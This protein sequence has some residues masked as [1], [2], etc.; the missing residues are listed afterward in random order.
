ME[1][2][3]RK[4]IADMLGVEIEEVT[5]NKYLGK[6]LDTDIL[7]SVEIIMILEKEFDV[8]IP[9]EKL[10]NFGRDVKVGELIAL[11]IGLVNKTVIPAPKPAPKAKV[12]KTVKKRVIKFTEYTY[13]DGS[14]AVKPVVKGFNDFEIVVLLSYYHDVSKV[15]LMQVNNNGA[16][17]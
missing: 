12:R 1:N 17:N 14:T 8:H 9:D 7:D 11:V 6:D 5:N 13:D 10:D 15:R 3:I 16:K 4:I 2:K